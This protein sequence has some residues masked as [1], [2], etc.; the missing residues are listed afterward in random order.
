MSKRQPKK[1]KRPASTK[2]YPRT[3]RLN[4]LLQQIVAE[5]F[6][7]LDDERLPFI[8]ITGVEVDSDLNR[9]DVFIST[10]EDPDPL[11]D[12]EILSIMMEQ[13]IPLQSAIARQAKLRKTPEVAIQFDPAVRVG[14][15]V[16]MILASLGLES[17]PAEGAEEELPE[18]E[19]AEIDEAEEWDGSAE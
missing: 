1:N 3:A 11:R 5:H 8:T 6:E 14:A 4:A 16:D 13:R 12:R 19:S 7:R 15:R 17:E 18:K 10:F 2:H 9:C